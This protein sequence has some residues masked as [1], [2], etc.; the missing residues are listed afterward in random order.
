MLWGEEIPRGAAAFAG[1]LADG[2]PEFRPIRRDV[3]DL[4][5][6]CYTSGTTGRPKGAM[7][8]HREE[9]FAD[10]KARREGRDL[11]LPQDVQAAVR[12]AYAGLMMAG[13]YSYARA[14]G[15]PRRHH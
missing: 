8:P 7:Q 12:D 14:A 13:A 10:L 2:R 9:V 1:W 4:A 11:G 5:A 15:V 6:I 3:G